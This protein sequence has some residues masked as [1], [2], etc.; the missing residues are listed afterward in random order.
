MTDKLIFSSLIISNRSTLLII[1]YTF[2]RKLFS[3]TAYINM[4][5]Q[6]GKSTW[7][8]TKHKVT[9]DKQK[10]RWSQS[11]SV[12]HPEAK[13]KDLFVLNEW[14]PC[15]E[16]SWY[17]PG[18]LMMG[19]VS[20]CQGHCAPL[21][22]TRLFSQVLLSHRAKRLPTL[23]TVLPHS[24]SHL[25][26]TCSPSVSGQHKRMGGVTISALLQSHGPRSKRSR[27][28][29]KS[30]SISLVGRHLSTHGRGELAGLGGLNLRRKEKN[31]IS[32]GNNS[33]PT[34]G[35]KLQLCDLFL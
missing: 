12:F 15:S 9:A 33:H 3:S 26:N 20:S 25:E 16:P 34:H 13:P 4:Q 29:F 19:K 17:S 10:W 11:H 22:A 30:A 23:Q 21:L 35:E 27:T 18:L 28:T 2:S 6:A 31:C 7:L 24:I 8:R 32:T 1:K 14:P 5:T